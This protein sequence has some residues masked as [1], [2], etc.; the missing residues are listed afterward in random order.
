MTNNPSQHCITWF[1]LTQVKRGRPEGTI[2]QLHSWVLPM[3]LQHRPGTK[4][5]CATYKNRTRNSKHATVRSNAGAVNMVNNLKLAQRQPHSP[6]PQDLWWLLRYLLFL[7]IFTIIQ[8][9]LVCTCWNAIRWIIANYFPAIFTQVK[10]NY[11]FYTLIA[12]FGPG[13]GLLFW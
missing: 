3:S 13:F 10:R 11:A 2:L 8:F 1:A 12:C 4:Q 7:D 5:Q 9:R 6:R